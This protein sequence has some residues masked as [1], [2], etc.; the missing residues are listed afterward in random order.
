MARWKKVVK[1]RVRARDVTKESES[2]KAVRGM[3]REFENEDEEDVLDA[4]VRVGLVPVGRKKRPGRKATG[5]T[6]ESVL[7]W[8]PLFAHLDS[9]SPGI[10]SK[11]AQQIL[12]V[13]VDSAPRFH[14]PPA[15]DE[16][17]KEVAS[18]RWTL[19]TWLL[20]LWNDAEL[21]VA[22]EER[23]EITKR[24]ARELVHSDDV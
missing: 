16:A 2:G 14:P 23:G 15:D 22:D 24:L 20:H 10:A 6:K 18:Y 8:T 4:V 3:L 12:T 11:L 21:A 5:P 1:A 9:L 13:L 19:G 17:R 7:V